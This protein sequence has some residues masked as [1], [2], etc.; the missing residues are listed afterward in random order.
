MRA[1]KRAMK[2]QNRRSLKRTHAGTG[3]ASNGAAGRGVGR[4]QQLGNGDAGGEE[5]DGDVKSELERRSKYHSAVRRDVDLHSVMIGDLGTSIRT[6]NSLGCTDGAVAASKLEAC[7]RD[8]D[9]KLSILVDEHAVLKSFETFPEA[10]LDAMRETHALWN[11]MTRIEEDLATWKAVAETFGA[12]L[13]NDVDDVVEDA[14]QLPEDTAGTSDG[15]SAAAGLCQRKAQKHACQ[16]QKLESLSSIC[17]RATKVLDVVQPRLDDTH[18]LR[19]S[20]A[21]KLRQFQIGFDEQ[22][23]TDA[24]HATVHV[25]NA[26][27]GAALVDTS[28]VDAQRHGA[29]RLAYR[30]Y[31]LAGGFDEKT[32][33]LFERLTERLVAD[34]QAE[35][36]ANSQTAN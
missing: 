12:K 2:E 34:A 36:E 19:E 21:K 22:R 29:L 14:S 33:S 13:D 11:E 9:E 25:A 30:V 28:N 17:S 7:L 31:Q 32:G 24:R 23:V 3:G 15:T 6:F 26:L 20:R 18:R 4:Q 35:D 5:G 8:T 27:L 1:F 16:K 10:K